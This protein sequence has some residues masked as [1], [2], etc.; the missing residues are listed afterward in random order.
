M[1]TTK[2]IIKSN[3]VSHYKINQNPLIEKDHLQNSQQLNRVREGDV[4]RLISPQ[5]EFL[6]QGYYG[7][8][9]KGIGWV[10]TFE[11]EELIDN[12]FF[13][14]K[15][16]MAIR[17]RIDFFKESSINTFRVFNGEGDGIGGFTMDYYNGFVVITWYSEGIYSF[18]ESIV[19][20]LTDSFSKVLSELLGDKSSEFINLKGIYQKKRFGDKG[21]FI[22]E[23]SFLRGEMAPEPLVALENNVKY[24]V[25]LDDGAMTGIF[26]DQKEVRGCIKNNYAKDKT[27]LNTFSYTGAFSVAAACG[28]AKHTT[29]VDLA[30]RSL[31]KTK[32]Q[33][34]I[35]G[36]DPE[37]HDIVVMDVFDYFKWAIKKEKQFDV[38]VLDPPAFA[39]SKKMTF[40][41]LKDY[42][43]LIEN[44]ID[45]TVKGGLI[46]AS[47]NSASLD[48]KHFKKQIN[49]GFHNKGCPYEIIETYT[50]PKDF[51]TI[52][53]F[54]KGD[55]LKV[56]FIKRLDS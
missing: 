30:K 8:Q 55:Y 26:L 41:V 37:L 44:A 35:N 51:T 27:V 53:T 32:E 20:L 28:G 47:T 16:S 24:A 46:I 52:P 7:I 42:T 9:N 48:M 31:E 19:N 33:F 3:K 5:G 29:S 6:G 4:L 2:I 39:K 12:Q 56:L 40:S 22:E 14:S 11:Q 17:K 49:Q 13:A 15:I 50:L 10:L 21:Q 54:P 18:K 1:N 43:W 38:V 36:I 45:L 25:Y 23:T 34:L